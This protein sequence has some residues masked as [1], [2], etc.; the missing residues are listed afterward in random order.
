ML[1]KAHYCAALKE[2]MMRSGHRGGTFYE[3][4]IKSKYSTQSR[5]SRKSSLSPDEENVVCYA[6]G[7]V[8][9][10]RHKKS[11]SNASE[12]VDN[13]EESTL[14]E[15]TTNWVS[16]VNQGSFTKGISA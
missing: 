10:K 15:Y 3:D 8:P 14:L 13:R 7:Y 6:S 12:Y 9:M 4:N 16:K 1:M 2:L 11:A 5:F